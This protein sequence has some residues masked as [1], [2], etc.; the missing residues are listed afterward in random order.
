MRFRL[1]DTGKIQSLDGQI[2]NY[3]PSSCQYCVYFLSDHQTIYIH[4]DDKDVKYLE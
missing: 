2:L 3:D 4:P 1:E